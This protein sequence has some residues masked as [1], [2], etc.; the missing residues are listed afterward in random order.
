L[1]GGFALADYPSLSRSSTQHHAEGP[2]SLPIKPAYL[3]HFVDETQ[4]LP[5]E[6]IEEASQP[7]SAQAV[8]SQAATT[9][10]DKTQADST[11]ADKTS[12]TEKQSVSSEPTTSASAVP[13]KAAQTQASHP[14]TAEKKTDGDSTTAPTAK[15]PVVTPTIE[16]KSHEL[17]PELAALR[18][19]VRQTLAQQ[20]KQPF[21]TRD[22]LPTDLMSLCLG[23]GCDTE[24]SLEGPG[25][26]RI[27]GITCLCWN[28]PCA[29]YELLAPT[30]KH[31]AARIGYGYQSQPGEF[32]AV[33]ALS[34]VPENYP[35]RSGNATRTIADLVEA[36]KLAC[37]ENAD[38]SLRLIGLTYYVEQPQW[39]NELGE[40]WSLERI[41]HQEIAQPIVNAPDGG[42]N[43]L[44][45]LSYAVSYHVNH[46]L[47]IAGQYLRAKKYISDYHDYAMAIQNSDGSW[48]PAMLAAKSASQDPS[49]QLA[50]T[51]RVLEWLAL[52]LPTSRME[53]PR[54][55]HAVEQTIHLLNVQRYQKNVPYL[56]TRELAAYG[57][58][59]HALALYDDR[60]FKEAEAEAAEA[61][62]TTA[63]D[64]QNTEQPVAGQAQNTTA[65]ST[66][67]QHGNS[68]RSTR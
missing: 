2:T 41:V 37:R 44:M 24:V 58:A 32:L 35:I 55:I 18:D 67:A 6:S 9:Q 46:D 28:Y 56:P 43:R 45:G 60:V 30:Q 31:I 57:H 52:S 49:V 50:S 64:S 48:G 59:L 51:G 5:V 23:F 16:K 21:N 34:R 15:T 66:T 39:K 68:P 33:L 61:A 11:Q 22:N 42:L 53:D 3:N 1:N 63:A 36:E 38:M 40:D 13:S 27:N 4:A 19:R 65:Q 12:T 26:K 20:Q 7:A 25:S 10:A 47:P 29:G 17:S 14:P 54:V 8:E 62:E